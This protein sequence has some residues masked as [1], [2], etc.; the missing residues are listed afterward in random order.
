MHH[1]LSMSFRDKSFSCLL[2]FVKKLG[3]DTDTIAAMS[4]AIWGAFNGAVKLDVEMLPRIEEQNEIQSV[5]AKLHK[6]Y[7]GTT[8]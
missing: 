3:G 1:G 7:Q 2:S 6:I 5:A 8:R 4:G